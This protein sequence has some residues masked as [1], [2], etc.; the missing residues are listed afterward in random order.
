MRGN[1]IYISLTSSLVM[2]DRQRL[3]KPLIVFLTLSFRLHAS[4]PWESHFCQVTFFND[5]RLHITNILCSWIR[6]RAHTIPTQARYQLYHRAVIKVWI[7]CLS[8]VCYLDP[9]DH[10]GYLVFELDLWAYEDSVV[11]NNLV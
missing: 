5:I 10:M 7:H 1:S 8:K 9:T 3:L 2:M 11:H 6:T 4:R